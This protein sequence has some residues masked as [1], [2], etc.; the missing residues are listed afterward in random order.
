MVTRATTGPDQDATFSF[1]AV[2]QSA[3]ELGATSDKLRLLVADVQQ[4]TRSDTLD[5]TTS[6]LQALIDHATKRLIELLLAT[7]G[8]A[9]VYRLVTARLRGGTH[10]KDATTEP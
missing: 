5:T 6:R 4:L 10:I 3:V 9:L 8:L 1:Q 2:T 7:F